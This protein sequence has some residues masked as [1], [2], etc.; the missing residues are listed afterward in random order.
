M[1]ISAYTL[2]RNPD[3]FTDPDTFN[4]ERF[5]NGTDIPN[6]AYVPFSAG[7]RNCIGQKFAMI[8]LKVTLSKILRHFKLIPVSEHPSIAADLII[9]S[10][11]GIRVRI[12]KR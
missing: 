11:N 8:E 4:P 9:K 7:P 10:V 1:S 5:I 3:V 6:Y 12:K 2:H